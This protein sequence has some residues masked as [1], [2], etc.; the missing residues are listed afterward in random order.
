[1]RR[2]LLLGLI[3]VA[4]AM[5]AAAC[6]RSVGTASSACGSIHDRLASADQRV[7]E[8]A[9]PTLRTLPGFTRTEGAVPT[10]ALAPQSSGVVVSGRAAGTLVRTG[11]V[12][13]TLALVL[14][15]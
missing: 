15:N 1:M 13:R 6:G 10:P 11:L 3:V 7:A 8:A 5:S 4:V 2:A 12:L 9:L 14:E